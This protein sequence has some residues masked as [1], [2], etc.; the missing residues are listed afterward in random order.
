[1]LADPGT[2]IRRV[3]ALSGIPLD[4]ELLAITLEHSSFDF[5]MRHKDKFDDLL[6]RELSER[7]AGLP[8]GGDSAKV[9][10]GRAGSHRELG[11][12]VLADMDAV[13]REDVT[14]K[15]GFECYEDMVD[16]LG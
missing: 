9:R 5:M 12:A 3:A 2:A 11:A 8:P 10:E 14:A 1:M 16:A 13:W 4:G 6:M 15:F 7:T